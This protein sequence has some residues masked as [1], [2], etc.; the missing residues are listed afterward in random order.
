M[1]EAKHRQAQRN[2]G[3]FLGPDVLVPAPMRTLSDDYHDEP[4]E[5]EESDREPVPEPPGKLRR[6]FAWL[7]RRGHTAP[8]GG[9]QPGPD[10]G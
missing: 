10:A 9:R 8:E 4:A 2:A 6:L 7:S 3:A 5:P 1:T